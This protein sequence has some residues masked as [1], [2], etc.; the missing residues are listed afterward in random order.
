MASSQ[1]ERSGLYY[2]WNSGE[3]GYE[4]QM[5]ANWQKIGPI[6]QIGVISRT[7]NTPP[8][9]PTAGDCYIVGP[10]PTG[11][12]VGHIDEVVVR[13]PGSLWEFYAPAMGWVAFV[14]DEDKLTAYKTS[15]AGWTTGV[16]I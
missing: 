5:D 12:W 10:I 7:T 3:S 6:M 16:A 13:R 4:N 1:D 14:D 2:G 15:P 11:A 8:G 9:S